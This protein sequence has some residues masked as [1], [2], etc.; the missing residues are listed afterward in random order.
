MAVSWEEARDKLKQNFSL[1][2]R[3]IDAK[4]LTITYEQKENTRKKQLNM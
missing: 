1:I 4:Q 2:K 3:A